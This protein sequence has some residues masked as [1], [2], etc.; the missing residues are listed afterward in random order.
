MVAAAYPNTH[1]TLTA[2]PVTS[3]DPG[4]FIAHLL[5]GPG[6]SGA[7]ALDTVGRLTGVVTLDHDDAILIGPALITTFL[8]H[9]GRLLARRPV[10]A[11]RRAATAGRGP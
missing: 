3:H 1:R 4:D 10:R 8:R 5:L 7:A 6:A 9:T 2:G 11:V